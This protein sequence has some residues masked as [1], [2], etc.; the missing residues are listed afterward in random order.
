M[1]RNEVRR[2]ME[3]ITERQ[4]ELLVRWREIHG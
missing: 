2:A 3:I 4:A 1:K